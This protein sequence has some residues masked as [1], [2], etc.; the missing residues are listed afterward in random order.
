MHVPPSGLNGPSQ[1][2]RAW[3][4][5]V[6][7]LFKVSRASEDRT[8]TAVATRCCELSECRASRAMPPRRPCRIQRREK[9]QGLLRE[10]RRRSQ[11]RRRGAT[12]AAV[13]H[14]G[15]VRVGQRGP[16]G[17]GRGRIGAGLS[18]GKKH[19]TGSGR[20]QAARKRPCSR[21]TGGGTFSTVSRRPPRRR[22]ACEP[23]ARP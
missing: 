10:P 15:K 1:R 4:S 19:T 21:G 11:L 16:G 22:R 13:A 9:A 2:F 8:D 17:T 6:R 5:A 18:R 12:A 20:A 14:C 23:S 7:Q 3:L